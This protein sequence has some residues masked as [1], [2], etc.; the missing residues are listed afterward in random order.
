MGAEHLLARGIQVIGVV[1]HE[2]G[3]AGQARGHDL[4][5]AHQRRGLPVAFRAEAVAVRHEALHGEAGE[6]R[7]AVQVLEGRRE[8]LEAAFLEEAPQPDLDPRRLLQLLAPR[9][10]GTQLLGHVVLRV[11][12]AEAALHLR[13]LHVLHRVPRGRRRRSR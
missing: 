9:A 7:E 5:R 12:L 6:L 3:A 13:V 2:R 4:H 1:F 10:S 11:V 8:G